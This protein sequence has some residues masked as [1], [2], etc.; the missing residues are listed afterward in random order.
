LLPLMLLILREQKTRTDKH[1]ELFSVEEA[2]QIPSVSPFWWKF[3]ANLT[4]FSSVL[5]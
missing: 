3:N 4:K 5:K 2:E 1:F